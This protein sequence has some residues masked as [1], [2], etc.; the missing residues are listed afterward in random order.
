MLNGV[1]AAVA[2]SVAARPR[3]RI[4]VGAARPSKNGWIPLNPSHENQD[5]KDN[6]DNANEADATVTISVPIAAEAATEPAGE[7]NDKNDDENEP[8]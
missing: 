4:T 2:S 7:E 5:E 1:R 8:D 3:W 6:H